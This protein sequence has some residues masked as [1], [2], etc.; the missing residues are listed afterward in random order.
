MVD[1]GLSA[2]YQVV[3]VLTK[4]LVAADLL[5]CLAR[6]GVVADGSRTVLVVDDD[7]QALKLAERSL[8]DGGFRPI[9]RSD[10][11]S[12]LEAVQKEAPT[13]IVLDLV[14][15]EMS[16]FDFLGRLRRAPHGRKIPVIVWTQRDITAEERER[17]RTMA[18]AVVL[19]SAGTQSLVEE[20]RQCLR[21]TG[22]K[23]S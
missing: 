6:I 13:A 5:G 18:E 11:E 21:P 19:K 17:L 23:P 3:D 22:P 10:G 8:R 15:P 12:G 9:C 20:L 16:G 1:K 2:G 14:M 4:P 7:P